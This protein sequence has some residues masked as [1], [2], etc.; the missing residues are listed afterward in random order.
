MSS[1]ILERKTRGLKSVLR[2]SRLKFKLLN[3]NALM[4]KRA[5]EFSA[6]L[7][8]FACID[9]DVR[10]EPKESAPIHTKVA[11]QMPPKTAGFIFARSGLAVSKGLAPINCVGVIDEDYRGEII[12][13]LYNH[14]E[15]TA[16]IKN[17]D[18]VAQLV[19][20]PVLY[21]DACLAE[22]LDETKRGVGGFGSTGR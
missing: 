1:A 22:S 14:S 2:E 12:V 16:V 4:P 13:V 9:E 19:I 6:G 18:R 21:E 8:L 7:D 20:M 17:H 11:A 3:E 15:N 5:T 10:I